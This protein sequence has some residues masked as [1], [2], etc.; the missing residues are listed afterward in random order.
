MSDQHESEK[1]EGEGRSAV[2]LEDAPTDRSSDVDDADTTTASGSD[3]DA[4]DDDRPD[5]TSD[6]DDENDTV[7][8]EDDEDDEDDEPTG[9]DDSDDTDD[10]DDI[11]DPDDAET[12]RAGG[13]NGRTALFAAL[14][15]AAV[16]VIGVLVLLAAFVWPNFAGPGKPDDKANQAVAALAS[17]DSAKINEV[18]CKRSDGKPA[19]QIPP[20]LL[21]FV[22]KVD[23]AGPPNMTLDTEARQPVNMT[24]TAQGQTQTLPV[25]VVLGVNDGSWCMNG[26]AERQ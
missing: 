24:L 13:S 10:D 20:E 4:T 6:R 25:E 17:K 7:V 16:A 2:Q 8:D 18:S 3:D 1:S 15:V 26:I 11:D 5:A 12:A 22:Q 23:P 14:A 19:A 9:S 21:Q